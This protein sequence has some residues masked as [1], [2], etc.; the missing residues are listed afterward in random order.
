MKK[1]EKI[2]AFVKQLGSDSNS[3][4][5]PCYQAYFACFNAQHYYEAHD[6]LEHLWLKK[7]SGNYHFFKGLIQIAG[8]FVHL[9][10]QFL[11]PTHPKD[12]K[13]L[14]PAV[15]LFELGMKN[16]QAYRPYHLNLDV[17]ELCELCRERVDEI[18]ESEFRKNPWHPQRAPQL[19]LCVARAS[20][21]QRHAQDAP[22]NGVIG[23]TPMLG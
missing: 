20:R 17:D 8:A 23:E 19:T 22:G 5:D 16:L 2:E 21:P 4:L 12:G 7:R 13:R 6:V 11:R 10:K 15:R 9:Q 14:R 18:V 1:S 3:A